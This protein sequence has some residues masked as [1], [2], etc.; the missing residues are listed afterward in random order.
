MYQPWFGRFP[1]STLYKSAG[2]V[3][4]TS[5]NALLAARAG[6]SPYVGHL[7]KID[8]NGVL[9]WHK[10][11]T[12]NTSVAKIKSYGTDS[13]ISTGGSLLKVSSTGTITWQLDF[14]AGTSLTI[15]N[16]EITP[17]GA[18][19][20]VSLLTGSNDM[21]VCKVSSG[22]TIAWKKLYTRVSSYVNQILAGNFDLYFTEV[23][24]TGSPRIILTKL[25]ASCVVTWS[26]SFSSTGAPNP[27]WSDAYMLDSGA[28][29]YTTYSTETPNVLR[30]LCLNTDGT[31]AWSKSITDGNC[32]D[33]S[34]QWWTANVV[35]GG[36]LVTAFSD[37]GTKLL[38]YKVSNDGNLDWSRIATDASGTTTNLGWESGV[39]DTGSNL[40]IGMDV[41]DGADVSRSSFLNVTTDGLPLV[42]SGTEIT[43]LN[44]TLAAIANGAT[45]TVA[46]DTSGT[47]TT[48]SYTISAGSLALTSD[49]ITFSVGALDFSTQ[50]QATGSVEAT[51]HGTPS[52][53]YDQ[54]FTTTGHLATDHGTP[55]YYSVPLD[56]TAYFASG[57]FYTNHGTPTASL[58]F[59]GQASGH[60]VTNHGA[61][62][63]TMDFAATTGGVVTTHGTPSLSEIFSAEGLFAT[64]HGTPSL[65]FVV[66]A[67]GHLVTNHGTPTLGLVGEYV[68]T[69]NLVT[70]HG[71]PSY[72]GSAFPARSTPPSLRHGKPLLVR[73]PTC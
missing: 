43:F 57:S 50:Y 63:A 32:S 9:D 28:I 36:L 49:T 1:D 6:S 53:T 15:Y 67:S 69:G 30:L 29:V 64:Q 45:F 31:V 47:V 66:Y 58:D 25:D 65:E 52:V 33:Y 27:V 17:N 41:F 4:I 71:T 54:S 35:V 37:D 42:T 8:G 48:P 3:S 26:K 40:I 51:R 34:L 46:S 10:K 22:G 72:T 68:A 21:V 2:V 20:L 62:E 60:L 23:Y 61:P 24:E 7:R 18:N 59:S 12:T 55:I 19:V 5:G 39:A 70:Q 16:F 13:Y 73:T 14:Q 56:T 44:N 11:F 38:Y